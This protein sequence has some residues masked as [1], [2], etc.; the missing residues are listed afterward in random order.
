[1]KSR[2][3]TVATLLALLAGTGGALA[4]AGQSSSG[5]PVGGAASGQYC[6]GK[7]AGPGKCKGHQKHHRHCNK[8][9]RGRGNGVCK[10]HNKK[11][12][13]KGK[14]HKPKGKGGT[15][16]NKGKGQTKTCKNEVVQGVLVT[17]C[18]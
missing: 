3:A 7:T 2:I 6:N 1:V 16:K 5:G 9:G 10:G 4:V 11:Q 14:N 8:R 17:F 13:S 18:P 12:G 15:N